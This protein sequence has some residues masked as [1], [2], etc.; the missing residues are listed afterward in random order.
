M[1]PAAK[2]DSSRSRTASRK[3]SS[4]YSAGMAKTLPVMK[5]ASV[6]LEK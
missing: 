5:A 4:R 2:L 6:A 1:K 3:W